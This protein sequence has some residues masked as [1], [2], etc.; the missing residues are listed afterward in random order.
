MGK[1]SSSDIESGFQRRVS[2]CC[3]L[4]NLPALDE[5][6]LRCSISNCE[7]HHDAIDDCCNRF[8]SC[9]SSSAL[10]CLPLKN[11]PYRNKVIPGWNKHV[12]DSKSAASFWNKV[13]VEAGCPSSG[14]LARIRV[15]CKRRYEYAVRRVKRR[16]D[17]IIRKKIGSALSSKDNRTFW[18]ETKSS[19]TGRS[20]PTSVVDGY[21]S[22]VDVCNT[23]KLKLSAILKSTKSSFDDSRISDFLSFLKATIRAN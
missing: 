11:M 10:E 16:R 13:W 2:S 7:S 21:C 22:D 5:S 20:Q 12:R 4:K 14:V 3:V 1:D 19:D 17:H 15:R 8:L 9:L 23:F 6:L 18:K